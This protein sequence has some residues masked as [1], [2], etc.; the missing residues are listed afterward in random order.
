MNKSKVVIDTNVLI[1]AMISKQGKAYKIFAAIGTELFDTLISTPLILEYEDV[2]KRLLGTKIKLSEAD[3]DLALDFICGS[4]IQRQVHYLW[5]PYLS[6]P[7][8]DMV[9]ELAANSGGDYIITYNISDFAG[10]EVFGVEA[11]IPAEFL[12]RL[13]R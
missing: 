8:D 13:E 10:S 4:G 12:A 3:V 5:R 9:L 7:K 2:L 11:I 1:A 6:D